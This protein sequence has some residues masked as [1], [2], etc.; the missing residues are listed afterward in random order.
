V[1]GVERGLAKLAQL[2]PQ[3]RRVFGCGVF[4]A[5]VATNGHNASV[6]H[7]KTAYSINENWG[8]ERSW[9]NLNQSN[10]ATAWRDPGDPGFLWSIKSCGG[11]FRRSALSL[12][13]MLYAITAT[14]GP[15]RRYPLVATKKCR[16]IP[17]KRH[18]NISPR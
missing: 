12:R 2:L 9:W 10:N 6:H 15:N 11:R 4:A 1:A 18:E 13:Y 8:A 17:P 7:S 3:L 16:K 14:Q 5:I